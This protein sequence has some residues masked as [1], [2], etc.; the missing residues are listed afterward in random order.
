MYILYVCVISDIAEHQ[1]M[2]KN[3]RNTLYLRFSLTH[4][5]G[6]EQPKTDYSFLLCISHLYPHI[7]HI[8]SSTLKEN[9][10]L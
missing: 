2:L 4:K 5:T 7:A 6:I 9:R 3:K 1:P 10:R 8:V